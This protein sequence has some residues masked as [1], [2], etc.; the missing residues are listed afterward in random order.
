MPPLA[1]LDRGSRSLSGGVLLL[2][3]SDLRE[4][5]FPAPLHINPNV[6]FAFLALIGF[7]LHSS[8]EDFRLLGSLCGHIIGSIPW[9]VSD[10]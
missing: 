3:E 5:L 7:V 4:G 2:W 10:E 6:E 9:S 8:L 1:A